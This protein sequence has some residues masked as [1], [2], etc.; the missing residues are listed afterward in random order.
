MRSKMPVFRL[1]AGK[2]LKRPGREARSGY[3]VGG[4]QLQSQKW[5]LQ[6]MSRTMRSYKRISVGRCS[7]GPELAYRMERAEVG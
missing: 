4:K 2:V 6:A 5:H 1:G 7:D 3:A